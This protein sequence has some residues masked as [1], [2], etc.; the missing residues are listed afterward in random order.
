[1]VYTRAETADDAH[2]D[3]AKA[4]AMHAG[5]PDVPVFVSNIA[6]DAPVNVKR[7]VLPPGTAVICIAG[8]ADN[9]SFFHYCSNNFQVN[10][11]ISLPDHYAYQGGFFEKKGINPDYRLL[12]TEKDYA[13][14]LEIAPKPE[15]VFY[16][17]IRIRIHPEEEFL[18]LIE[19]AISA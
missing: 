14:L 1:L 4:E 18:N 19:K 5:F 7:E 12:C 11:K 15:M 16:L 10:R 2:K 6:Y 8:L 13:K 17:P 9:S 3:L